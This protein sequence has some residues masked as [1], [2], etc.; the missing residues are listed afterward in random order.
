VRLFGSV[1]R[2]ASTEKSDL[3]LLVQMKPGRSLLVLIALEQEIE[4]RDRWR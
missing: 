2:G 1:A 3:D 4:T